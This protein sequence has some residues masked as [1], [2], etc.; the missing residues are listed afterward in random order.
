VQF[1]VPELSCVSCTAAI[2]HGMG[3]WEGSYILHTATK[4]C[5]QEH[6]AAALSL[7]APTA[8]RP[9]TARN[10]SYC[11][12]SLLSF[13]SDSNASVHGLAELIAA[14]AFRMQGLRRLQQP[15]GQLSKSIEAKTGCH[16]GLH[17]LSQG[18]WSNRP[19]VKCQWHKI[20]WRCHNL[21][22]AACLVG[23]PN[24]T[25]SDHSHETWS[26]KDTQ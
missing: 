26:E 24:L 12:D 14:A 1:D 13:C 3:I 11:S 8:C 21:K 15:A 22:C 19:T 23:P 9:G 16:P 6:E 18:D 25:L 10:S 2:I 7:A 17:I 20:A 5:P 4:V